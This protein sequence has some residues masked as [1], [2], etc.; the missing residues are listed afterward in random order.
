[1]IAAWEKPKYLAFQPRTAWSLFNAF[2]EVQKSRSPRVQMDSGL[3]L[4]GVFRRVLAW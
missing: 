1:V 2:T 3:R 4:S